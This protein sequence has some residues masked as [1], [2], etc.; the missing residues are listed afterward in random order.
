M[1]PTR[2]FVF[3]L[4]YAASSAIWAGTVYK[5]VD[6]KGAAS[7]QDQPCAGATA[8]EEL[9]YPDRYDE[10]SDPAATAVATDPAGAVRP[11]PRP[12]S[13]ASLA[14]VPGPDFYQCSR[15]DGTQ[16]NSAEGTPAPYA[17]DGNI[18]I[19]PDYLYQPGGPAPAN[20]APTPEGYGGNNLA[21]RYTW[22]QDKCR[23]MPAQ[24][25]CSVIRSE[26]DAV[27][28]KIKHAFSDT[29]PELTRREK[30]LAGKLGD[31]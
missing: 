29:L 5:C 15:P 25:A 23:R 13:R 6:D 10:T 11:G 8:T 21:V 20:G 24:E 4:L 14:E 12:E 30:L 2:R 27:Q 31:C 26:H 17:V 18:T 16:Y 1:L 3:F 19:P 28:A 7:Y 9:S 22:V